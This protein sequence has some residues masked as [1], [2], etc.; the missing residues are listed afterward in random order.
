MTSRFTTR[1][2]RGRLTLAVLLLATVLPACSSFSSPEPPVADST[3]VEVLIDL[4]LASARSDLYR[5]VPPGTRDSVL[6]DHG[7]TEAD[8]EAA[9]RYYSEHPEAYVEIYTTVL[10]RI[11]EERQ[12]E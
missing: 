4:Q 12:G 3:L 8:F 1:P 11:N 9:M 2:V 7:L 6:A 5:D 10:N